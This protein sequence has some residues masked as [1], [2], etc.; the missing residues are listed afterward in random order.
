MMKVGNYKFEIKN[1]KYM[2][3]LS[4]ETYCFSAILYANGKNLADCSNNG[5]GGSTDI[6]FFPPNRQMEREIEDFLKTQPPIKYESCNFEMD[7]TLEYI[8][9]ELVVELL[10][11]KDLK[12]LRKQTSKY[13]VFL[14]PKGT[15]YPIGWKKYKVDELLK[16]RSGQDMLK[17]TIAIHVAKGNILINENIPADLL[18]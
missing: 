4:E 5:H 10:K 13:L 6:R 16:T 9:D 12:K 8:V 11:A 1:F 3:S 7:M 17:K 15:Y 2:E 18:P 14:N